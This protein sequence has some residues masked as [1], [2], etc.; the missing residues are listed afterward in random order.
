MIGARSWRSREGA[1]VQGHWSTAPTF[2]AAA[3]L[4]FEQLGRS[5]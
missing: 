4:V 1:E 5:Q 2:V 3:R